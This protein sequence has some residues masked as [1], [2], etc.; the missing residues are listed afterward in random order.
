[1]LICSHKPAVC[2]RVGPFFNSKLRPHM[3]DHACESTGWVYTLVEV[4]YK[5]DGKNRWLPTEL[6]PQH[7]GV[8]L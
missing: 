5:G 6:D 1:M 8:D 4:G 3:D 2:W 7:P